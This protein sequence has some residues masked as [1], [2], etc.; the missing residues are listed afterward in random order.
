MKS[1][2]NKLFFLDTSAFFKEYHD[3]EGSHHLHDIFDQA[4]K[5]RITLCI[6]IITISEVLNALDK[7]RKRQIISDHECQIIADAILFRYCRIDR[8]GENGDP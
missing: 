2:M 6:S 3:E 1:E 4:K 7:I 8:T 5:G